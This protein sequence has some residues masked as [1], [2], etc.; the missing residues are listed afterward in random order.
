MCVYLCVLLL[1]LT[2]LNLIIVRMSTNQGK[3]ISIIYQNIAKTL[4]TSQ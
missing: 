4:I 3:K 2:D 1:S